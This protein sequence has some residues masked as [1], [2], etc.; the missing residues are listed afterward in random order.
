MAHHKL[1]DYISRI[2]SRNGQP[3]ESAMVN[4][5]LYLRPDG[6]GNLCVRDENGRLVENIPAANIPQFMAHLSYVIGRLQHAAEK[7]DG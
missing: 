7:K 2:D 5:R 3:T 6:D 4:L 1:D